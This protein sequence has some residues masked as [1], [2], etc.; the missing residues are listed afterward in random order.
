MLQ[1]PLQE[2]KERTSSRETRLLDKIFPDKEEIYLFWESHIKSKA[3]ALF[4]YRSLILTADAYLSHNYAVFDAL[5]TS[6]CCHG[7]ALL[8]YSLLST[9]SIA[10]IQKIKEK[11][12]TLIYNLDYHFQPHFLVRSTNWQFLVL[13]G[14]YLLNSLI[15]ID[16][17][18]GRRTNPRKLQDIST[19]SRYFADK[20]TGQL[21]KILSQKIAN[22]YQHYLTELNPQSNITGAPV[23][24]WGQYVQPRYLRENQRGIL[25]ASCLFSTQIVMSYMIEKQIKLL[26][27]YNALDQNLNLITRQARLLEGD[28]IDNFRLLPDEETSFKNSSDMPEPVI[29]FTGYSV[30]ENISVLE[31]SKKMDELIA[32]IPSLMLSCNIFYPQFPHMHGDPSFN[33]APVIPKELLLKK[34]IERHSTLTGVSRQN[35]SLFCHSH[36]LISNTKYAISLVNNPGN[37][38]RYEDIF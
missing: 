11:T 26:F 33:S 1:V 34:S 37:S 17:L 3:Q 38:S 20:I 29:I 13:T 8:T 23:H 19:I 30:T 5:T 10:E 9:L 22:S 12:Q 7:T 21:Q 4:F 15:E 27:I 36:T 31:V 32:N 35:P 28:G 25:C 14:L 24:L 2:V 16:P 6:N 18:K